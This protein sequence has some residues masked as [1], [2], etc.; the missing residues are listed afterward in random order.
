MSLSIPRKRKL[1]RIIIIVASLVSGDLDE[2]I[3]GTIEETI[4]SQLSEA[5]ALLFSVE[6]WTTAHEDAWATIEDIY[7]ALSPEALSDPDWQSFSDDL[8]AKLAE[9]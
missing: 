3:D 7:N 4:L 1:I 8:G 6:N 5:D 9:L 2:D